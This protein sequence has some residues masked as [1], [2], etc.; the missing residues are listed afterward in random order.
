[1]KA[2]QII[3]IQLQ[4]L[5]FAYF[6]YPSFVK[7]DKTLAQNEPYRGHTET[8]KKWGRIPKRE[9]TFKKGEWQSFERKKIAFNKISE[10]SIQRKLWKVYHNFWKT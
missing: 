1:M 3:L 10:K 4:I 5:Q 7:G 6:F 2:L 9:G 8:Y